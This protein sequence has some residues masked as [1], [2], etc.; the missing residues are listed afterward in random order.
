MAGPPSSGDDSSGDDSGADSDGAGSGEGASGAQ[1][2]DNE[3]DDGSGSGGDSDEDDS[4]D[5]SGSDESGSGDAGSGSDAGSSD[6]EEASGGSSSDEDDTDT[7]AARAAAAMEADR[8]RQLKERQIAP[9]EDA[10]GKQFFEADPF[11]NGK[12]EEITSFAGLH[13]SRPLLRAIA[14]LGYKAPTPI[15]VRPGPT[16]VCLTCSTSHTCRPYQRRVIPLCLA[17]RDVCGS[18]V[19]GSGKTAAF[20]LPALERLLFRPKHIPAT[21]VLIVTPTRELA[22]QILSMTKKLAK[23]TDIRAALAVGGHSLKVQEAD[24]RA[25]PEIVVCTPGRIIDLLRN[26]RSVH[27]DDVDILIMDEADRLLEMGFKDEVEEIIRHCPAGRQTVLLS[28]TMVSQ[29]KELIA[30]SLNK[31]VRVSADPLYDV[32]QRLSQEFVRIRENRDG[33]REAILVALVTRSFRKEVIVFCPTK[34]LA[35]RLTLVL[36]LAG[37]ECGELHGDLT[38]QQ[39]L[40]ALNAFRAKQVRRGAMPCVR[41]VGSTD[42]TSRARC[43]TDSSVGGD[44]PCQPRTGH[45]GCANCDQLHHAS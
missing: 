4:A 10:A 18:A 7:G 42:L 35:H 12:D 3:E 33:D 8:T 39:R 17:G 31:P 44:R 32:A 27:V 11:L 36:G 37:V 20:L 25:R 45:C 30:L 22:T 23:Y 24:L 1:S 19:T 34:K 5:E 2:S 43:W 6:E 26:S 9:P 16:G 40:D 29:V 41:R 15:Q 13:L 21:R 14:D 28:A 38:Q